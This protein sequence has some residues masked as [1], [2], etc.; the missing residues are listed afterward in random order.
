[1]KIGF[2]GTMSVGKTT[3]VNELKRLPEFANYKV[4]TERS[5]YLRD[6]GIPLNTDSTLKGQTIFLAE[7]A[8]EL[9]NEDILTDRTII[10]VMAFTGLAKS[11][12]IVEADY[13]K[14]FAAN[15]IP[16]YDYIFYVSPKGV[17]IEDNGVR[18]IDEEYRDLVDVSI[19]NLIKNYRHKMKNLIRL[20]GPTERRVQQ[21]VECITM[22]APVYL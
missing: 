1:M 14:D 6:L 7:R 16:E 21:V 5:Q 12:S 2:C 13:F 15:L 11:V 3:L 20:E 22:S 10:D 19:N 4:A 8:A 9:M 18:E 17:D